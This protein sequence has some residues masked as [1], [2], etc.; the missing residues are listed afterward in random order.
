[1]KLNDGGDVGQERIGRNEE[2][3]GN[4]VVVSGPSIA[5]SLDP[6]ERWYT[7]NTFV[8]GSVNFINNDPG[9]EQDYFLV[10]P[11]IADWLKKKK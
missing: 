7:H 9:W 1:M 6:E 5:Y 10:G 4:R 11:G 2:H 3:E 8:P